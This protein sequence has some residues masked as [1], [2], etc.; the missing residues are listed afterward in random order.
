MMII[1]FCKSDAHPKAQKLQNQ[2]F[3]IFGV[4]LATEPK[5]VVKKSILDDYLSKTW[6]FKNTPR[7]K[8]NFFER[9][10][11]LK[12]NENFENLEVLQQNEII[13]EGIEDN[14]VVFKQRMYTGG[15]WEPGEGFISTQ[16]KGFF[17]GRDGFMHSQFLQDQHSDNFFL[18]QVVDGVILC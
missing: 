17:D 5:A 7:Q 9:M 2:G 6:P 13:Q 3:K 1:Q 4:K 18:C 16:F 8:F 11:E 15:Q 14:Y 10:D 12:T